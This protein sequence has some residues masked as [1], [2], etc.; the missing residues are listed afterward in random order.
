MHQE[1]TIYACCQGGDGFESI[2]HHTIF[3]RGNKQGKFSCLLIEIFQ[4]PQ[5]VSLIPA[6]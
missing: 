6:K 4:F 5:P 2:L 3:P 1:E